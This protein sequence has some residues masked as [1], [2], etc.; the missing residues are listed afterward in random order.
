[1]VL[2][3]N[4][5]KYSQMKLSDKVLTETLQDNSNQILKNT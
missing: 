3:A 4:F 5:K 1:V 2:V